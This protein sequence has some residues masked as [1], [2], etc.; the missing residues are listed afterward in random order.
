MFSFWIP[1]LALIGLADA[2][3][4]LYKKLRKEKL[5]CFFGDDCDKVS[6]SEYGYMFGIPSEV[7]GVGFYLFVLALFVLSQ[8]GNTMGLGLP[9]LSLLLFAA[10][11]A[12]L[13]SLYLLFVQAFILKKWCEWCILSALV[14]FFILFL[15]L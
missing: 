2:S 7:F 5:V 15:V 11:S 12:S 3:Y 8:L 6:K 14:N 10:I 4:L 9:L 1:V 13:A